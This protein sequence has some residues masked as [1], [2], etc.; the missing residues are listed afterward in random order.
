MDLVTYALCKKAIKKAIEDNKSFHLMGNVATI[1]DL[2][3]NPNDGDLYL[4]GPQQDGNYEEYY[5]IASQNKWELMGTTAIDL[6]GYVMNTD[7]ATD[8]V[9]GVF[10]C[11]NGITVN[12]TTGVIEITA[13][14]LAQYNSLTT[15]SAISKGT[16]E[17]ALSGK[18]Y[19]TTS[20]LVT[21][22]SAQSTDTQY[23]SAKAVYDTIGD[24]ESLLASANTELEGI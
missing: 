13:Y 5:W 20:N 11:G 21:S 7:Y 1:Q 4:V 17:A 24:I 3:Q 14:T 9:G 16:L 23:P 19:Q 8:Q 2:P 15:T 12:A 22:L 18:G 6:T 10:K